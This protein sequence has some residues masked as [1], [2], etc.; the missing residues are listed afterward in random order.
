MITISGL[1]R[2]LPQ[3][4][5]VLQ[6]IRG[7]LEP[8]TFVAIVG[9]SGSGK[10][11]LLRCLALKEPWTK[12]EYRFDG[13]EV[14]K[15][16][17]LAKLRV[18]RKIAYLEQKPLLYEKKTALKNVLIGAVG[19]VS[20]IRRVTGMVRNDDYMDAMDTLEAV[21][22][23]DRAKQPAEKL[24]G[25]ERQRVAI[26]RAIAHGAEL[27]LAD[28]PVT[29]LDPHSAEDIMAILKKLCKE[30][31][32][33]IV[34]ALHRLELAEKFADEIWGLHEGRIIMN[35]R[36]RRLTGAEKVRLS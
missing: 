26:A 22:L 5:T 33:T 24:S 29:G 16:G 36:G 31:R 6:E 20:W 2:T 15:A 1:T 17:P 28:E 8:G 32:T 10:S 23:I 7:Q 4:K 14:M 35:V 12:G 25:G 18:R 3:G 34:V 19:Q 30:K 27:V 11:T 13:Q 21:G 9:A